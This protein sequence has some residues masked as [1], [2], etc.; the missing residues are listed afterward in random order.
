MNL[1]LNDTLIIRV[2]VLNPLER[3]ENVTNTNRRSN[4]ISVPSVAR[5]RVRVSL[6]CGAAQV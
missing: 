4:C 1:F 3:S 2:E 6:C 5:G